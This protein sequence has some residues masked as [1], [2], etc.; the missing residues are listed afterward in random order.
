MEERN[1]L[2][3]QEN[4]MDSVVVKSMESMYSQD[5]QKRF[6]EEFGFEIPKE[7]APLPS[8][9]KLYDQSHPLCDQKTVD[10]RAM[11]AREEDILTSNALWKKGTVISQL[12]KSCL[13][14]KNVD[15]SSLL[16]GD[17]NALLFAIRISGYGPEYT[18]KIE[19]PACEEKFEN[20]FDLQKIGLKKL[21]IEPIVPHQ[22]K[23][24]F[25]LPRT[26]KEVIFKFQTVRDDEEITKSLEKKHSKIGGDIDTIVTSKLINSIISFDGKTDKSKIAQAVRNLPAMDAHALR[27]YMV[28]NEPGV[29]TK[30][31][32]TCPNCGHD[33]E[34]TIPIGASFFWP[35][36]RR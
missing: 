6:V 30:C 32:V 20:E 27:E 29:D 9:G 25:L 26:N 14:D 35:D 19:C 12:V 17:R 5:A 1:N 13:I 36:S 24:K 8:E 11:T 34:V 23:F 28:K 31:P 22:N 10:L 15:V 2:F 33:S 3:G 7:I 4:E 21:E 18:V 16:M